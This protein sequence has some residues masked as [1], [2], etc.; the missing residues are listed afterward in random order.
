MN[1]GLVELRVRD[2]YSLHQTIA[3]YAA[4]RLTERSALKR[5]AEY[6]ARYVEA[7]QKD[8]ST[9]EVET[10]NILAAL[11]ATE[12]MEQRNA[13][14]Q[15]VA[16]FLPF[17]YARGMYDRAVPFAQRARDAGRRFRTP[18]VSYAC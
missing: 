15:R 10:S 13:F 12:Q 2:R 8:F 18:G 1:T 6:F 5:M 14:V 4:T 17:L 16:A 11:E 3:D 7:H 9:L